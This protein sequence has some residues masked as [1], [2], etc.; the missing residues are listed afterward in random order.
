MKKSKGRRKISVKRIVVLIIALCLIS[1]A[2]L[3]LTR[4]NTKQSI[5]KTDNV[6]LITGTGNPG[7]IMSF[8]K[9]GSALLP[10]L[11][12]NTNYLFVHTVRVGDVDNDKI[13][14]IVAGIS[15]SFFSEPYGCKVEEYST[16]DSQQ[17]LSLIDDVGDVRCKDLAIGDADNDGK[18]EVLLGTHG[19]GYINLY[20]KI[21]GKWEKTVLEDNY[22]GKIDAERNTTHKVARKDLTYDAVVNSAVHIV[23][24]GDID[25]DG[26]NEVVATISSPLEF[27]S[28]EIS[29]IRVYR[30]DKN[31]NSWNSSTLDEL[32]GREFRSIAIG[33]LYG[34]GKN[35]MLIGIGTPGK[36]PG[37]VYLY[38][39]DGSKWNK[40]L[41]YNDSIE[42][43]MK[44]LT[45]GDLD[46]D[47]KNE[48]V[49][50]TGFPNGVVH[51]FKWDEAKGKFSDNIIGRISDF[52]NLT[53]AE[54]NSMATEIGD[55][56]SD[57]EKEIIVGGTTTFPE[58]KIGWEGADSG[59]LV[60]FKRNKS[61]E[62]QGKILDTHNILAVDAGK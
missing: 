54:F 27:P 37:S 15:N 56:D 61:G 47:G 25:N 3:F 53:G 60:M 36:N 44:G 38:S 51:I 12:L 23:K 17:N 52:F 57:S 42:R 6:K 49:L 1:T 41:F 45:I 31:L 28:D 46:N 58:K 16:I 14:E 50:A 5:N 7:L 59:Y 33:D 19:E 39:Y 21:G 48:V 2:I 22:I 18:N 29:F 35:E 26:K 20:K 10:T 55:F 34:N 43:N 13:E 62:W 30:Y 11:S 32:H 40:Q 4:N 8:A 24:I 9:N